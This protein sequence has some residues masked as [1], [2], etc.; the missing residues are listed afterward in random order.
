MVEKQEDYIYSLGIASVFFTSMLAIFLG[1]GTYIIYSMAEHESATVAF[2]A[3]IVVL[4]IS[5]IFIT[6][7]NNNTC[8]NLYEYS[9]KLYGKAI[10]T[11]LNILIII[12]LSI[13]SCIALYNIANFLNV[14]YL[15]ESNV[16]Y[17]KLLILVP[18]IYI[19]T[20]DLPTLIKC[21]QVFFLV[22]ILIFAFDILGVMGEVHLTNLE[23]VFSLPK[24][25]YIKSILCYVS[26]SIVPL[27]MILITNKS[28]IYD[29]EKVDKKLYI[30]IA[31]TCL[32]TAIL[33][34]FTI[35]V[36]GK[37]YISSFRFPEYIALKQF[38]LF[39]IFER[40]ENIL[41]LV[42]L[43]V[44]YCLLSNLIYMITDIFE[45]RKSKFV[46]SIVLMII[47]VLV[48]SVAFKEATMFLNIVNNYIYYV[49][50]AGLMLPILL[51]FIKSK[52]STKKLK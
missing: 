49:I 32:T 39:S 29:K 9:K 8:K 3:G 24:L 17:L 50:L 5:Y 27:F 11:I 12:S 51:I 35:L 37:E 45:K 28:R 19:C 47:L 15:P 46:F 34:L 21:N 7:F 1:V 14:E 22:S 23:P 25:D 4:A 16:N 42:Y 33:I 2:I 30:M 52:I 36:L 38:K 44:S 31:F 20:K 26:F 10:G 6:I 48:S 13:I 43:F 40:I 41:S 18:I